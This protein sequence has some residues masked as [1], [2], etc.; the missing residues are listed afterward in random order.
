MLDF[1]DNST[2]KY[3]NTYILLLVD[4]GSN[5]FGIRDV[6]MIPNILSLKPIVFLI[7]IYN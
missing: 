4:N 3:V 1:L 2:A 5:K 6:M 7:T